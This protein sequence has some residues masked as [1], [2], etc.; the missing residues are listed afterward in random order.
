V[1]DLVDFLV[2]DAYR[3]ELLP[4]WKA[5]DDVVTE[6]RLE[7]ASETTRANGRHPITL[8]IWRLAP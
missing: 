2:A 7:A 6:E 1:G 8:Q 3:L 4:A 5:G